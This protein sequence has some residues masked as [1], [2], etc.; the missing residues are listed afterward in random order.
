MPEAKP[1]GWHYRGYLPHFDDQETPQP[2]CRMRCDT[3][4]VSDT[5]F[6]R[7]C[8]RDVRAPEGK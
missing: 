4:T 2:L 1:R 5:T 3:L 8:G 6:I 7:G